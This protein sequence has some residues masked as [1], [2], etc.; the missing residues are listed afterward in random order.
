MKP[1]YDD[2]CRIVFEQEQTIKRLEKKIAHLE[3]L[4]KLNSKNSSKPP[5]SDQKGS[6]D[7]PKKKGGAKPGHPQQFPLK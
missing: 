4:L 7:T 1:T 3:E 2:L 6:N 5:S